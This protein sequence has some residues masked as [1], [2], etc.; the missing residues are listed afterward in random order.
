VRISR[1]LAIA[2]SALLF[3]FAV[4]VLLWPGAPLFRVAP[5]VRYAATAMCVAGVAL[6]LSAFGP[7]RHAIQ[8]E[9]APRTGADLV[10]TGVY[11]WLRHP[12]YT[13]ILIAVLGLFLR[14]PSIHVAC[15]AAGVM[16]LLIIKTRVE[17]RLLSARYPEYDAYRKRT[18]GLVPLRKR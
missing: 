1:V 11:A 2:Q 6:M 9:P 10:T 3:A 13:G 16:M 14:T 7:L 15:A 17:E 5:V 18:F 4:V 8:I 12:I